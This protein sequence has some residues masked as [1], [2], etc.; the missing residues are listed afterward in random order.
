MKIYVA[1]LLIVFLTACGT[2]ED[3]KNMPKKHFDIRG[4]FEKE[5]VKLQKQNPIVEKTVS[6]NT[7][8]EV[9]QLTIP[10]WKTE[11]ELFSESDINK[12]AWKNSYRIKKNGPEIE[13]I[14]IDNSLRTKKVS[15]R[16]SEKGTV[17][18]ITI[19]NRTSNKLYT[20]DEELNYYPDSLYN[21]K[22]HQNV[23][24]IG[25]NEYSISSSFQN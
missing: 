3:S 5:A 4:Y 12:P 25:K 18:Q 1:L 14:S 10:D 2:R 19:F 13:Y 24:V 15:I 22:M 20:S 23:R 11:F 6:Q 21:I 9:K 16:F 7:E 8:L 17:K